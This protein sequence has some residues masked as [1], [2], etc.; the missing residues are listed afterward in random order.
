ME[1]LLTNEITATDEQWKYLKSFSVNGVEY[2]VE[3]GVC[4]GNH[5]HTAVITAITQY[6]RL[7]QKGL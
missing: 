2:G 3:I 4:H 5:R 7:Y 1:D 6:D